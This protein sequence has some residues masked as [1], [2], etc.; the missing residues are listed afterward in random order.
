MTK[1]VVLFELVL[2]LVASVN[3][4]VY[5]GILITEQKGTSVEYA[6]VGIVGKN[7][8]TTS[9]MDG[10]FELNIPSE[11]SGDTIRFSMIGYE[12]ITLLVS[13]FINRNNDTI[14]MVEKTYSIQEVVISAPKSEVKIL[15][16]GR[17]NG[18][19]HMSFPRGGK[20]L[21]VGIILD[22]KK[23]NQAQLQTLM[24]NGISI[25]NEI[26]DDKSKSWITS[27]A[28]IDTLHFRVNLYR[29]NSKGEF[30]NILTKP[31]YIKYKPYKMEERKEDKIITSH[32]V[33]FDISEHQL[34]IDSKS[35]ITVEF[36]SDVPP[37][38]ALF[39]AHLRGPDTYF[40]A[41]SQ[42]KF[43]KYPYINASAGLG[44]RAKV[45]KQ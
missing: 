6:N 21:E 14:W 25:S 33:E 26:Y 45:M 38:R 20:G 40:R 9:N 13:D 5:K 18:T 3:A 17:T 27:R 37:N 15:G 29:V 2:L 19:A 22:L 7:I 44:V 28:E 23:G 16:N 4:Q 31:I 43:I 36:Y 41:T 24:L 32:P 8:G 39:N 34:V 10:Q 1:R 12:T 42:G 35:L 11:N 30:E